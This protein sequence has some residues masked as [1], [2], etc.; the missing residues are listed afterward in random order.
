MRFSF[1]GVEVSYSRCVVDDAASHAIQCMLFQTL[2]PLKADFLHRSG[3][4]DSEPLDATRELARSPLEASSKCKRQATQTVRHRGGPP[5]R[6][7]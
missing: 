5:L 4:P 7:F 3:L 6:F 2:P 1:D